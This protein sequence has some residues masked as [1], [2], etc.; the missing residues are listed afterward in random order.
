MKYHPLTFLILLSLLACREVFEAPEKV[1]NEGILVVEGVIDSGT[2]SSTLKLSRTGSLSSRSTFKEEGASVSLLNASGEIL[3]FS[4][5]APGEYGIN[6]PDLPTGS[7]YFLKIQTQNGQEYLSDSLTV[8]DTPEIDSVY[9]HREDD[10]VHIELATNNNLQNSTENYL[11]KYTQTWEAFAEYR[12]YLEL[13]QRVSATGRR[14]YN[15]V[16]LQKDGKP[17]FDSSMYYCWQQEFSR[18]LLINNTRLQQENRLRQPIAFVENTSPKFKTLWSIE[19]E[20]VSIS[21]KAYDFFDL[22]KK[23][24]E[25]TGS[26]FDPQPAILYGNIHSV[27]NPDELVIGY[28]VLSP[29]KKKRIFIKRSDVTGWNPFIACDPQQFS[30]SSDIIRDRVLN[31]FLPAYVP[32]DAAPFPQ[33]PFFIADLAPCVNCRIN[34]FNGKPDFWPQPTD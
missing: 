29:V 20:Q 6:S 16:Y 1:G 13:E 23:N 30:N 34:G 24:T 7:T 8:F 2:G 9:W 15:V 33:V 28:A 21:R 25:L 18:E 17:Y 32:S 22:M 27:N 14:I 19:V 26:I 10:G 31:S 11:W 5:N 4:E 12:R 3:I